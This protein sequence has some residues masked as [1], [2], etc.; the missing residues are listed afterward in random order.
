MFERFTDRARKVMALA[1]QEAQ[2]LNHEYIDT[3]HVLLGILKEDQGVGAAALKNLGLD[4]LK[5]RT[6]LKKR[7]KQGPDMMSIDRLPRPRLPQTLYAKNTIEYA[8]EEARSLNHNYVGTEHILLGLIRRQKRLDGQYRQT[9][10][11]KILRSLGITLRKAREEVLNL[12]GVTRKKENIKKV[13]TKK[14]ERPVK[15]ET[16][17]LGLDKERITAFLKT[18][19]FVQATQSSLNMPN[20]THETKITIWYKDKE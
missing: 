5:V 12:L 1:N 2:R 8:I 4:L 15:Y 9:T 11:Q 7:I 17:E 10:A 20:G 14:K 16:F 6:E 3:E 13:A 18:I 19:E